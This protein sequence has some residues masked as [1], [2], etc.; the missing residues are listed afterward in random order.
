MAAEPSSLLLGVHVAA[1][2][3][4]LALGPAT[5]LLHRLRGPLAAGY[6]VAVAVLTTTALGLVAIDPA[7]L[8][9]LVPFA[10]GTEAAVI[11]GSW[12]A[13]RTPGRT[14]PWRVRLMGGSYVSLITALLVVSWGRNVLAWVLPSIV[15]VVV[16]ETAAARVG[17]TREVADAG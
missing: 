17:R 9:W 16:V 5:L 10:V 15:G 13:H 2:A 7:G 14:T 12:L 8:W 11:G 4:A 1:G 3:V 6:Q